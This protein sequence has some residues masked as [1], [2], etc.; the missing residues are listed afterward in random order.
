MPSRACSSSPKP[1]R[2][3]ATSFASRSNM[4]LARA[5]V[6]ARSPRSAAPAASSASA[7]HASIAAVAAHTSARGGVDGSFPRPPGD[8]PPFA[9]EDT[10]VAHAPRYAP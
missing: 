3:R 4:R 1:W 9:A 10:H 8:A 7:G 6:S 5:D 2:L